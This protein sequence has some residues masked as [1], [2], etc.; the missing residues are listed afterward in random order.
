MTQQPTGADRSKITRQ[1]TATTDP[2]KPAIRKPRVK[3]TITAKRDQSE[4][5][6]KPTVKSRAQ[7]EKDAAEKR[8]QALDMRARRMTYQ[9]IADRIGWGSRGTAHQQVAKELKLIPR[10][11]AKELRQ[12]ELESLDQAERALGARIMQGDLGAI[13]RM[14]KI[15]DM[16]AKLTGLYEP[17]ADSGVDE[18]R[19]VLGAFISSVLKLDADGQLEDESETNE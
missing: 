7:Y 13:D 19:V 11:A 3:S 2:V 16:R 12:I 5:V 6:K 10:E 14:I 18:V 1:T 8:R 17:A 15:K 9:Q 4:R